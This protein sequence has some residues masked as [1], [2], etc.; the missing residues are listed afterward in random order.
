MFIEQ[1]FT[2][3]ERYQSTI[4][5]NR[6]LLLVT[7]RVQYHSDS[8]QKMLP[9][10]QWESMTITTAWERYHSYSGSPESI[11]DSHCKSGIVLFH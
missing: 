2:A 6:L 1:N 10:L 8:G 11:Q 7:G 4:L 5:Y 9:L 3:W